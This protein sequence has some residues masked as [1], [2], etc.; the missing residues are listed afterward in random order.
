MSLGHVSAPDVPLH[1][2]VMQGAPESPLLFILVT[3]MVFRGL[4]AK[5]EARG[6]GWTMDGF[7]LTEICFADDLLL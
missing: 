5:W 4:R 6:S 3:E 2:G 1:R 7:R